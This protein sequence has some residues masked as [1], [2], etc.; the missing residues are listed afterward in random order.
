MEQRDVHVQSY[1]KILRFDIPSKLCHI[2][3][4]ARLPFEF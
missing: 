1:R 2:Q 3:A 4:H